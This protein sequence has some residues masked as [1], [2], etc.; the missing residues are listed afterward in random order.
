M[1]I[2]IRLFSILK[3]VIFWFV[4]DKGDVMRVRGEVLVN[5]DVFVVDCRN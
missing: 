2:G 5:N 4:I 3:G 1:V